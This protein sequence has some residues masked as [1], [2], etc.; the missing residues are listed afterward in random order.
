MYKTTGTAENR[1]FNLRDG[2]DITVKQK[3]EMGK[4]YLAQW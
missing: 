4:K 1:S 3:R 2:G